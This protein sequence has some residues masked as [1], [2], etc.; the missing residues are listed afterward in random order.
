MIMSILIKMDPVIMGNNDVE[1][2]QQSLQNITQK[3]KWK[4][5]WWIFEWGQ[6]QPYSLPK[7][8]WE[9]EN[10]HFHLDQKVITKLQGLNGRENF[11]TL[12]GRQCPADVIH[13]PARSLRDP[14]CIVA[15]YL[16]FF[17]LFIDGTM[18]DCLVE[19]TNLCFNQYLGVC[20]C[21]F[22]FFHRKGLSWLNKTINVI[23]L[24]RSAMV[25]CGNIYV[26]STFVSASKII[27][28]RTFNL[29]TVQ[30]SVNWTWEDC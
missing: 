19:K 3:Q 27:I 18:F 25:C 14:A 7:W 11:K 20:V 22:V 29:A 21:V 1:K 4:Q 8:N 26:S 5:Y 30:K 13:T 6:L 15:T 2:T 28:E 24:F 17:R 12:P 23:P 16:Y 10:S 9:I